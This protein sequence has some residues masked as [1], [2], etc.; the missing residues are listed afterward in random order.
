MVDIFTTL[1]EE[2][3]ANCFMSFWIAKKYQDR[4]RENHKIFYCPKGHPQSYPGI[5]E[6]DK[7][8][9]ELRYKETVIRAKGNAISNLANSNRSL[10]GVIS[11]LKKQVVKSGKKS[12]EKGRPSKVKK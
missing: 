9:R 11:K 2:D 10:K 5:S 12:K 4:L 8:E 7:L 6:K 1:V 3:C